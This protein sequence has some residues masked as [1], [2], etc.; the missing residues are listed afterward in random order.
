[1]YLISFKL[2]EKNLTMKLGHLSAFKKCFFPSK[3]YKIEE[4]LT[5]YIKALNKYN[6][7]SYLF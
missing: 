3:N 2:I 6:S 4:K 7:F 1:M 5:K